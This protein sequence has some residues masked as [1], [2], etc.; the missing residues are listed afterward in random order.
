MKTI[1]KEHILYELPATEEHL[2]KAFVPKLG[3]I[4]ETKKVEKLKHRLLSQIQ[5]LVTKEQIY[6]DPNGFYMKVGH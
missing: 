1:T 4:A 5:N 2:M 6:L 3:E